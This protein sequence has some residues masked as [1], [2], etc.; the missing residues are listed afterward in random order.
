LSFLLLFTTVDGSKFREDLP[1]QSAALPSSG[2]RRVHFDVKDADSSSYSPSSSSSS[3][4]MHSMRHNPATQLNAVLAGQS[5][6][7]SS[8]RY[9][10]PG[11]FALI[12]LFF[13]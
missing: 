9:S 13:L 11:K 6:K 8:M 10:G 1:V 2:E 3:S 7:A 4:S 5:A 12:V